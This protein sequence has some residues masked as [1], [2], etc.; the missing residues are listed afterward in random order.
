MKKTLIS[1]IKIIIANVVIINNKMFDNE[2]IMNLSL[3]KESADLEALENFISQYYNT[4]VK[5]LSPENG[6]RNIVSDNNEHFTG[7]VI[8]ENKRYKF[9][10]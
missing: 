6:I 2:N 9:Y 5:I 3:Q 1:W 10:T 4:K 8:Q 7:I